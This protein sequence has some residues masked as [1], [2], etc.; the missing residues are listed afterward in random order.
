M[1]LPGEREIRE[2]YDALLERRYRHTV[3]LP[4]YGRMPQHEQ[5]RVFQSLPERRIVLATNVAETSITIPGI[6]FVVDSGL[7]RIKRYEPRTGM[8]LLQ[9]EP[10]SRASAEQRKGRAGRLR[11]G[12]CYRLYAEDEY[13]QRPAYTVPEVQRVGLA[14]VI[15]QMKTLGLGRIEAFPFLDPPSKR[16]LDEGYRVLEELGAIDQAGDPTDIG[17]T[18]VRLPL[19][20]RLSRMLLAASTGGCLREVSIIAA[21]LSIQDPRE[22]PLQAQKQADD[23]HRRFLDE[24][25]DFVSLLKIWRWYHNA[26]GRASR[27]QLRKLC[28]DSFLSFQRMREWADVHQ[29]LLDRCRDLNWSPNDRDAAVEAIHA[30]LLAGL[31]GRTGMWQSEKRSYLGARQTRFVLHPSSGLARK[32]PAWVFAAEIVETSQPFARLA[33]A[34]DPSC[35]ERVAGPLCKHSYHDPHWEQ[36]PAQVVAKENVSL[37]GLPIVR[38]RR[39]PFAPIDPVEARRIF[40]VHALVR[41][42][43]ST[44][45]RFHEHNRNV[46][47]QARRLRDKARRS[48]MLF[49]EDALLPFFDARVPRSVVDGKTFETWRRKA[50]SENPHVLE[51]SLTDVLQGEA[52]DLTSERYPDTISVPGASLALSYRFDPSQDDDGITVAVPVAFLAQ[53][54]PDVLEWTIPAWHDEKVLLLL[55]SLPRSIRKEIA[56][57]AEVASE[58]AHAHTPFDG[59][60]LA[61]L[62]ADL[63]ALTGVRVPPDAWRLDDLPR[64]L[65]FYFKVH[66][67]TGK[68]IGQGR[69]LHDLKRQLGPRAR[70]AW[71]A[72]ARVSWERTGLRSWSFDRLPE[73]LP[74]LVGGCSTLCYPALVDDGDSVSLRALSSKAEAE[75][76]TRQ[77]LRRLFLLRMGSAQC[78]V[79]TPFRDSLPLAALA[80]FVAG[81]AKSLREQVRMRAVDDSFA[82]HDPGM[83]PRDGE[84]FAQH[85]NAG[86]SALARRLTELATLAHDMGTA[87]MKVES[88][89]RTCS[90]KPGAPR[91]ALDD[92]RRHMESLLPRDLF[93]HTP[94]DRIVHIPRYLRGVH[95]RLERLP[96][97]PRRDADKASH[98]VPL[99][100]SFQRNRE[101]L[102]RRGVPAQ[103]L[104]SFRWL[105]EELRIAIFAP[106]LRTAMSVSPARVAELWNSLSA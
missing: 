26:R 40:L 88:M 83:F 92:I 97:D 42:E 89:L 84:A 99:W 7:A 65:R 31:L 67:D 28:R 75:R 13:M 10:V 18:L 1:F 105:L 62:A 71:T 27:N 37:F 4:L 64:H 58:I 54:D 56:P 98:V 102:R 46:I 74:I 11:S 85:W 61:A 12:V 44:R 53:A 6:S 8:T 81:D 48:D 101:A 68:T 23:A 59:P 106:E 90:G 73:R 14:G 32:P 22:R 91:T 86:R 29:Q 16:F 100:E 21:A 76:A 20:P 5:L 51:L 52:A 60:M 95:I 36:R 38:D 9:V 63:H 78:A 104:E 17:R 77:G 87:V 79:D 34:V 19:D 49:D 41:Q 15:L 33:A 94:S 72:S 57:V 2:A 66:D 35:I 82:L 80:R 96:I 55:Q 39:V 24:T 103:D 69:N 45:G 93:E 30:A 43:L 3:L 47:E 25:S 50:E 70:Q